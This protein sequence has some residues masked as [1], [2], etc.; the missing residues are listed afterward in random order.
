V[1]CCFNKSNE[2]LANSAAESKAKINIFIQTLLDCFTEFT[3]GPFVTNM[4]VF[5]MTD[6]MISEACAGQGY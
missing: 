4:H 6:D 1:T 2:T 5:L 3:S